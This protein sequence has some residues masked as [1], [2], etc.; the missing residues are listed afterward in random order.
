VRVFCVFR[1]VAVPPVTTA[2]DTTVI[3]SDMGI[4]RVRTD[5]PAVTERLSARRQAGPTLACAPGQQRRF[6]LSG[7]E[8]RPC[9]FYYQSKQI[10]STTTGDARG[11]ATEFRDACGSAGLRDRRQRRTAQI[12]A[13]HTGA[14]LTDA[15]PD[16]PVSLSGRERGPSGD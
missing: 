3:G 13:A 16:R 6:M 9:P 8:L 11:H 1:R 10:W 14:R 12:P 15:R 2:T 4:R 5:A 7:S